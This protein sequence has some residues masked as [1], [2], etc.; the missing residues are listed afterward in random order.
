M[1]LPDLTRGL[2]QRIEGQFRRH[3]AFIPA[4]WNLRFREQLN[5][6]VSLSVSTDIHQHGPAANRDVE[7]AVAAADSLKQLDVGSYIDSGGNLRHIFDE[8]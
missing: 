8:K 6:G 5:L 7:A 3:W 4:L 1:R 2:P